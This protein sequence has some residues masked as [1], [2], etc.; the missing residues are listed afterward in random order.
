M[1]RITNKELARLAGGDSPNLKLVL[2]LNPGPIAL[3]VGGT[4]DSLH[5]FADSQGWQMGQ[6]YLI[7]PVTARIPNRAIHL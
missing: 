6:D 5:D 1:E 3:P 4:R 7:V 2:F